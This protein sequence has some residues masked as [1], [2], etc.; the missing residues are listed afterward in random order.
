MNGLPLLRIGDQVVNL[1]Q[2]TIATFDTIHEVAGP[3]PRAILQ[4][5]AHRAELV[6]FREQ[7]VR[8]RRYLEGRADALPTARLPGEDPR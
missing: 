4:F 7:A 1:D 6:L 3:C 2:L 5:A 8:V